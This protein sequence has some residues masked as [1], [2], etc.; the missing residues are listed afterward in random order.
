[1]KRLSNSILHS[2]N[3]KTN[4]V[5]IINKTDRKIIMD[6]NPRSM[7]F[8]KIQGYRILENFIK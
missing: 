4:Q 2:K 5:F 7:K 6:F 3:K 8:K 1:M